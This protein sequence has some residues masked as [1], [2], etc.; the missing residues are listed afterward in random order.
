[1]I[2]KTTSLFRCRL[3]V[4]G[5]PS[6]S[7]EGIVKSFELIVMPRLG[8]NKL[9]GRRAVSCLYSHPKSAL[10]LLQAVITL[11]RKDEE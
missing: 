6:A 3:W 7:E 9:A 8:N 5:C 11:S 1:M 4:W 10:L 2:T